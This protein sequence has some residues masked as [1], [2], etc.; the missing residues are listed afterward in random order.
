MPTVTSGRRVR[1]RA[2]DVPPAAP[3]RRSPRIVGRPRNVPPAPPGAGRFSEGPIRRARPSDAEAIARIYNHEVRRSTATFDTRPRSVAAQRALLV[4][5]GRRWPVLVAERHGRVVAWASLT[6]W[7]TRG[8]YA[9]TAES[10]VYVDAASRGRGIGGSLV[11]ALLPLAKASGF[12]VLLARIAE[13]RVASQRLHTRLGFARIGTLREVG[14]KFGRWVDVG[15][16]ERIVPERR[17]GRSGARRT[18]GG[19]TRRRTP[20]PR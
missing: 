9:R 16:W 15:M 13:D 1:A 18:G 20:P 17:R 8:A 10:S 12:H 3:V 4:A 6:P 5:H 11:R 14:F 19:R 2:V 7:S